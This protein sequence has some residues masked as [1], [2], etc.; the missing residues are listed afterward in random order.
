M[1]DIITGIILAIMT[2]SWATGAYFMYIKAEPKPYE[3]NRDYIT[4]NVKT[5]YI[6]LD[7][8]GHIIIRA[9][10]VNEEQDPQG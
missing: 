4:L 3:I 9:E 10:E 2:I 8:K 7:T 6:T 1:K 5:A